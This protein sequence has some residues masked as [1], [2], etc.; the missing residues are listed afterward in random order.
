MGPHL[1]DTDNGDAVAGLG[2]VHEIVLQN[3]LSAAGQ[4]PWGRSLWQ[5]LHCQVLQT[6]TTAR[7]ALFIRAAMY[8]GREQHEGGGVGINRAP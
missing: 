1:V 6:R 5:L 2:S 8:F 3:Y 7:S 4:L